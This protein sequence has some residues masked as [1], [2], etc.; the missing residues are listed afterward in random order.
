MYTLIHRDKHS[1]ARRGQ[2]QTAHGTVEL[3]A[4]M[5]VGTLGTVKGVEIGQLQQTG[6]EKNAKRQLVV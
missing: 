3:P 4:F 5:P 1:S 6:T 2:L